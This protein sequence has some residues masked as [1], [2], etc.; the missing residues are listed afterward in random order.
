M[1]TITWQDFEKIDL[2]VG[3]MTKLVI[4]PTRI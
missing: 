2:R 4:F 3:T 1:P